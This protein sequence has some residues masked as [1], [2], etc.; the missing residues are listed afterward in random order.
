M[1]HHTAS[2]VSIVG[3]GRNPFPGEITLAHNGVLFMDEFPEFRNNIIQALRQP[4]ENGYVTVSRAD[5]RFV[6]PARFMLVASMNPCPCGYLFDP[7][8]ECRCS[9][10]HINRYFMKISGPILDRIDIQVV[11]KPLKPYDVIEGRPAESSE[12]IRHRVL[13]AQHIQR[14]R[15]SKTGITNN[16]SMTITL[17]KQHCSLSRTAR[18]LLYD[19][20]EKF[21]LTA[22]SYHKIL[23]VARTVA[24]LDARE[25]ISDDDLLEALS[26]REVER[27][28]YGERIQEEELS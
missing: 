13:V 1:P 26:F 20:A 19:A 9:R 23:R 3:G 4:L 11:V 24:D 27:I 22:R 17:I 14:E 10:K 2:D 15:F 18:N 7:D 28:L 6:Y 25:G 8:C 5:Y 16:S 12:S 21:R